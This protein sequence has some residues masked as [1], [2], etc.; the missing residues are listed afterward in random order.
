MNALIVV[1]VCSTLGRFVGEGRSTTSVLAGVAPATFPRELV[2]R[3]VC[4]VLHRASSLTEDVIREV[5]DELHIARDAWPEPWPE[6]SFEP[7]EDTLDCLRRLADLGPVVALAN[8]SVTRQPQVTAIG[9]ICGTYLSGNYTSY[10]LGACKPAR[11]LWRY[12]ADLHGMRPQQI[13]HIGDEWAE[14]VLGP[15][16]VGARAV[17]VRRTELPIPGGTTALPATDR[18]TAVRELAAAVTVVEE[19]TAAAED[20]PTSGRR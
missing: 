10:Q 1:D 7:Y 6:S 19:W 9:E 20:K 14:D 17:W 18:W 12:I 15:L 8:L 3:T 4:R 5:C 16:S 11:W 13:I 2:A